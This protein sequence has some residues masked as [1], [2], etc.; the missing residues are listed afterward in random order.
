MPH[1]LETMVAPDREESVVPVQPP[2]PSE[3]A[4]IAAS[5]GIELEGTE[6]EQVTELAGATVAGYGRLDELDVPPR[7]VKY[8][9]VD[10]G[11]RPTGEENPGNGWAWRCSIPGAPEGPL[12][13]VRVAIKDNICVAGIPMLNGTEMLEGYVPREDA[14]VVTRLLDAGAEV[15]GKTA[16]PAFCFDG[17][18]VTGYPRP[19]PVNPHDPER[20]PGAS[21]SGSAV[22]VA[23]GEADM[24]LGGDQGGSIRM[25]AS[26]SGV[27]GHKPTWGLVP[28]TGAFPIE[29]TLDHL[30][31]ICR[32]VRDC[33]RM[34]E[35][36]AG[37]DGL[38]PRWSGGI[39]QPYV[40]E[41]ERGASGLRV[42]ILTEGFGWPDVSEPDVDEAVRN[43]AASFEG[44]GATVGEVSVPMHRDGLAIWN[45]IAIEGATELMVRGNAMGTNWRGHYTTD[46]LDF[47]SRA[48]AARAG[49]YSPTV[50][51]TMLVGHY[52]AERYGRHY[53]AKGQNLSRRLRGLYDQVL[54]DFDVLVMP[55]T[56]MKAM[57]RPP[58]D[59]S[60]TDYV[61]AALA[62]LHNTAVFDATGHPALSVPCGFSDG[63][64]IGMMLVGRH[65]EDAM[66]L[67]A[68]HAYET[69]R[70][71]LGSRNGKA[72]L[73]RA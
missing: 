48:R 56:A 19:E 17:G 52:M 30:G 73:A 35:V 22:V 29:L 65:L 45:A 62:N 44:L 31:P 49:D 8:P 14:T 41:I 42:G 3:L 36:L 4:R 70:G 68:A 58:A 51:L 15:I 53:Y 59:A 61:M 46:L 16:V 38:D 10:L 9:R 23:L 37:D 69:A 5:Y 39:A 18:S 20:L 64:P 71:E 34:L 7:P 21:S 57:R 67:R 66:V 60:F 12:A 50:K 1:E 25:P 6:L 54:E 72:A 27:V 26:W 13:G 32:S 43:A 2:S 55:T 40:E 63:L 47:Y 11:H 33:A 24:A 28:Y